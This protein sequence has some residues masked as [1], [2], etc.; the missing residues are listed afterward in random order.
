V[1]TATALVIIAAVAITAIALTR[2]EPSK[3]RPRASSSTSAAPGASTATPSAST[4]V[5]PTAALGTPNAN[6]IASEMAQTVEVGNPR[7]N[8]M[9]IGNPVTVSDGASGTLTAVIGRRSPSAD[10]KGQLIFFWHDTSFLGWNSD[11]ETLDFV[12]VS[13]AGPG[14]ID[15]QVIVFGPNDPLCCPTSPPVTITYQWNGQQI[16]PSRPLPAGTQGPMRVRRLP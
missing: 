14:Q 7:T 5:P 3:P 11:Q 9:P 15:A 1:P 12:G 10:G 13:A 16:A 4:A 2:N 8:F 6:D